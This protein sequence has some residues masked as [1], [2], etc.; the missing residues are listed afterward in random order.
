MLSHPSLAQISKCAG[1][2]LSFLS[3]KVF[4][5]SLLLFLYI[6]CI[7][8]NDMYMWLNTSKWG[9]C[10]QT[11]F[12]IMLTD[13][14]QGQN[15]NLSNFWWWLLMTFGTSSI[16]PITQY[17]KNMDRNVV[18]A[19]IVLF[20]YHWQHNKIKLWSAKNLGILNFQYPNK[21][22]KISS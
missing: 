18:F 9:G 7:N 10:R 14:Q 12:L 17:C 5:C 21:A 4:Q 8:T 6:N 16:T 13:V 15:F 19:W 11:S 3:K 2:E 22:I 20:W 1:R